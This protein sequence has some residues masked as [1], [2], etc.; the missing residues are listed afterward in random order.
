MFDYWLWCV[1]CR[2][3]YGFSAPEGYECLSRHSSKPKTEMEI[4]E[5]VMAIKTN[6]DV[7]L[8]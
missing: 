6:P 8:R 4:C 2:H 7:A 3:R 1:S 5:W